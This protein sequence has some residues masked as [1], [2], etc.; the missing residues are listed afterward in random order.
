MQK[1]GM[2]NIFSSSPGVRS[3]R[4]GVRLILN[5]T[6]KRLDLTPGELEK[7]LGIPIFCM[8][9]NEYQQLYET[10]AEGRMLDHGSELGKQIARLAAKLAS[11]QE[12]QK[13]KKR[14]G[15]FG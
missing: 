15:W 3:S 10:Y 12:E 14:F 7:M 13:G 9:P 5:R 11:L 6:P 8:I 2:P 1:I 4:L